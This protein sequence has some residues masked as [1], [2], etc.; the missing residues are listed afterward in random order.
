[1]HDSDW[2][3]MTWLA[4]YSLAPPRGC[5][6]RAQCTSCSDNITLGVLRLYSIP[7]NLPRHPPYQ[8]GYDNLDTMPFPIG[9]SGGDFVACIQLVRN[10]A[11]ALKDGAGASEHLRSL[12][13]ALSSLDTALTY[14]DGLEVT[15]IAQLVA[16]KTAAVR[17]QATIEAFLRKIEKFQPRLRTGGSG[18][19]IADSVRKAQWALCEKEDVAQLQAEISGHV[20]ALVLLLGILQLYVSRISSRSSITC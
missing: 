6:L 20:E 15:D 3:S 2:A 18:N 7:L 17:C 19:H 10:T 9:V 1:M 14:I 4:A 16:L 11:K 12:S 5:T 8:C 13:S